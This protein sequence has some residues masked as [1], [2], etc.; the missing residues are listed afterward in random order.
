MNFCTFSNLIK[1]NFYSIILLLIILVILNVQTHSLFAEEQNLKNT[2]NYSLSLNFSS[3]EEKEI[4]LQKYLTFSPKEIKESPNNPIYA[5]NAKLLG[6]GTII[7]AD[8][9][10]YQSINGTVTSTR[11]LNVEGIPQS[12]VSF[13]ENALI[14]GNI[15]IL[16]QGT[17]LESIYP[18]KTIGKGKGIITSSDGQSVTWNAEDI[19][20]VTRNGSIIYQGFI[21]F[22]TTSNGSLSFLKDSVGLYVSKVGGEASQRNIWQWTVK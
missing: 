9:P 1:T 4:F 19:G 5:E 6:K 21:Y 15:T 14:N 11:I 22:D 18:N 16:N 2:S 17:F 10:F 3:P 12:E 8:D 20:K 13:F 7:I